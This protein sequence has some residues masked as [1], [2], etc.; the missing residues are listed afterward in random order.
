MVIEAEVFW[1]LFEAG[2]VDKRWEENRVERSPST[3]L[4]EIPAFKIHV[5]KDVQTRK[6]QPEKE[7]KKKQEKC[8]MES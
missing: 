1:G 2:H 5:E 4:W 3:K 8:I 6:V 7:E